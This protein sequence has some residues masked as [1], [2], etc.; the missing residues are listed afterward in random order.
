MRF[1]TNETKRYERVFL[2]LMNQCVLQLDLL[3]NRVLLY[4]ETVDRTVIVCFPQ[5]G[6]A[7]LGK[8]AFTAPHLLLALR[9]APRAVLE[10]PPVLVLPHGHGTVGALVRLEGHE[11]EVAVGA[12]LDVD[13]GAVRAE[14]RLEV[15]V[16]DV[17]R[18]VLDVAAGK[19]HRGRGGRACAGR[20]EK[21]TGREGG[22]GTGI[23]L[24]GVRFI[25]RILY[26]IFTGTHAL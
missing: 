17:G 7:A 14:G 10:Q 18:A 21:K 13:D 5:C 12:V 19:G 6:K 24:D 4:T 23:L 22:E 16:G 15:L 2:L 3:C 25:T 26:P 8:A 1:V 9:L 20:A 11:R